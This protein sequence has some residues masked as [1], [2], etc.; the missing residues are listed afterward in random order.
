MKRYAIIA[1]IAF[2]SCAGNNDKNNNADTSII[3]TDTTATLKV[4][5]DKQY[6]FM[7]T[8]GAANQV[9]TLV[10][11]TLKKKKVNGEMA[12]LPKEKDSRKGTLHGTLN[13]DIVNDVWSYMQ[14]GMQDAIKVSFRLQQ[15]TLLQKPLKVNATN[16]REETDETAGYSVEYKP[17]NC[18]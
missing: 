4:L 10:S 17:G 1:A 11:F 16:G 2:A 3:T 13:G 8:E 6:C 14:E 18:N 15:E 12:W 5:Q 9:T 7:R